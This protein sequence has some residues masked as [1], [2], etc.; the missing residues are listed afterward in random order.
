MVACGDAFQPCIV[1]RRRLCSGDPMIEVAFCLSCPADEA[2]AKPDFTYT[3]L[4]NEFGKA[5][6][7]GVVEVSIGSTW[8]YLACRIA[9]L[10]GAPSILQL[11]CQAVSAC[12]GQVCLVPRTT[13]ASVVVQCVWQG[14]E[15]D[16][17]NASKGV[18]ESRE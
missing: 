16:A 1:L 12:P 15:I 10:N 3:Q 4:W 17:V 11:R 9:H 8:S 13:S 6:K 7:M 18:W 14:G 2:P 5:L